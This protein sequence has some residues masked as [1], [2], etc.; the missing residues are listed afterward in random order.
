MTHGTRP[1]PNLPVWDDDPTWLPPAPLDGDTAA[2]VCVIGLGGSGLVAVRALRAQGAD[3]IGIDAADVGAGA[4][5]RNGGLLLAG[6]A[7]FHHDAVARLGHER[8]V[9]LYRRTLDELDRVFTEFP[10]CTRRTGSLRIAASDAEV[11]DCRAQLT[12]MTHD[13]LPVEWYSGAEGE[14][15]LLP[16]DGVMQPLTRVRSMARRAQSTGARLHSRSRALEVTGSQVVT[17]RGVIACRR[18]I[19][20]VDGR[21]DLLLPELAPRVRT[22]RLQMLATEPAR[23]VHIPRPVYWRDG[24]EYWQQLADGTV[25][26][27]GFRDL[28]EEDEWTHDDTPSV[29]IQGHLDRFL[30]EH[31]GTQA[32]VTHRWG[33]SVSYSTTGAPICEEVRDGVFVIGAYSGTGNI[34]GALCARDAAEWAVSSLTR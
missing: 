8:A 23:D 15:L 25:A 16:T 22:A 27:G 6:L 32:A 11:A 7:S 21:L 34:V 4:A 14:G 33:A 24:Y 30:R 17:D 1:A 29:A 3:V 13:G 10:E 19:V 12:Q 18:V 9:A 31:I 28:H 2:D 5:G 20:A 26:V